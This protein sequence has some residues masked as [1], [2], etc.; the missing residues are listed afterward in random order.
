M[1]ILF[2]AN[3]PRNISEIINFVNL[4]FLSFNIILNLSNNSIFDTKKKILL[5]EMIIYEDDIIKKFL[6]NF[7]K[8]F[9]I[10]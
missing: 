6:I 4:M 10:L 7:I 9:S 5:N 1:I 2:L 3:I 8:K